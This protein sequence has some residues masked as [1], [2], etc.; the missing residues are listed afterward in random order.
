[1]K[2]TINILNKKAKFDYHFLRQEHAGVQL[3]GSEVKAI[4]AGQVSLV[5]SYCMFQGDELFVVGMN[6]P[7]NNT[8]YSHDPLRHRKLLLKRKE[9]DKLKKEL[10][11]GVTIIPTRLYLNERGFLKIEVSVCKGKKEYDKRNTIKER[12]I[13]RQL[14]LVD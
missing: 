3:V 9:L 1:M 11:K 12:D 13:T 14:N 2:Q 4:R 5:D 8:A 10:I 6:I 7:G